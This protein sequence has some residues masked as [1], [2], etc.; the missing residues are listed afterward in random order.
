MSNAWYLIT[1][2][3]M[4]KPI[5]FS[6]ISQTLKIH[7]KMPITQIWKRANFYFVV[8]QHTMYLIIV[9]NMKILS[10]IM[11][12]YM[13][14]DRRT[15]PISIFLNLAKAEQRISQAPKNL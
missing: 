2:P 14:T 9:P 4:N 3:H 5:F 6:E 8:H 10:A 12:E 13:R 15:V 1:V 11:E 7:E